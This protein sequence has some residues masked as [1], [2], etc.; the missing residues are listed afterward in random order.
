MIE[1]EENNM[2][3]RDLNV[4][5]TIQT[6]KAKE[7]SAQELQPLDDEGTAMA[8]HKRFTFDVIDTPS[9]PLR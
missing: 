6:E 3:K 4:M 1:E 8:E 7:I 2:E 5:D 9:D